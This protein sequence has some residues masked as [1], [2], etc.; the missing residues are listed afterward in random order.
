M[1]EKILL[2]GFGN[3]C[4][5]LLDL[6]DDTSF[7][8]ACIVDSD[9][10]KQGTEYGKYKIL[11]PECLKDHPGVTVCVTF[12]SPADEEP[13]WEELRSKYG[14]DEMDICSYHELIIKIYREKYKGISLETA[15][16]TKQL[17]RCFDASWEMGL[18]GV[19]AWLNDI[20]NA[21]DRRR[22]RD[23]HWLTYGERMNELKDKPP[24]SDE[25]INAGIRLIQGC[26]PCTIVFSRVNELM[27]SAYLLK[28]RMP[29]KLKIIMAV[30]GSCDGLYRD[31]LSYRDGIDHYVCVSSM[32]KK[33][34]EDK[35][36]ETGKI[37]VMTIPV[38]REE[39]LERD[40]SDA[41]D[42][43]LRLGYA[44]RLEIFQK[45]VDRL[46]ELASDLRERGIVFVLSIAGEGTYEIELRDVIN[47]NGMSNEVRFLGMID[48]ENIPAFWKEQDIALN[49]S[50]S[51]GRPLS[52]MEA[53]LAGCV[54]VATYTSGII[55]DVRDGE[56]GY[57][58]Q[59]GDINA[60]ADRI[61]YLN[62]NRNLLKIM[63]EQAREDMMQKTNMDRHLDF[64]MGLLNVS[65]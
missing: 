8:V 65:S 38:V 18:G 56:N 37:S 26:L 2:Y 13:I 10:T 34:F 51:E 64:W 16:G 14:I 9:P 31:V 62:N 12:L 57:V 17:S 19:E 5:N 59:K 11:A 44:G 21:C 28:L 52:N 35:G 61:E 40:Y 53:M 36:V 42:S 39:G 47:R 32:I 63:G 48:R 24:F 46:A 4:R 20:R 55:E 54:P 30:H 49:V 60:M 6:L 15:A 50:D 41:I 33:C 27:L 29:D 22:I 25:Y 1:K 7:E 45:R 23:I 58:V 43:P 3:R